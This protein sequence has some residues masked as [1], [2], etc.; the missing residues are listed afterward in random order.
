MGH[1]LAL[2]P[3]HTRDAGYLVGTLPWAPRRPE[4]EGHASP[5]CP[6]ALL[7]LQGTRR[8]SC[9]NQP[10]VWTFGEGC[11]PWAPAFRVLALEKTV[12]SLSQNWPTPS[13]NRSLS[14]TERGGASAFDPGLL[15]FESEA[16]HS[17]RP[18]TL[19]SWEAPAPPGPKATVGWGPVRV[20]SRP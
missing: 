10:A 18:V 1:H 5:R 7:L 3:A 16:H 11:L 4:V 20:C 17:R 9:R 2:Q 6:P 8:A 15:H 13:Q 12:R 19:V 14:E